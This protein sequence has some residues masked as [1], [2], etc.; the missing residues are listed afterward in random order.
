MCVCVYDHFVS[1][2]LNIIFRYMEKMFYP[3]K[4]TV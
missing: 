4:I 1:V 3:H 2:N